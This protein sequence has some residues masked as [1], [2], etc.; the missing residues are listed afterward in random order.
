MAEGFELQSTRRESR[1]AFQLTKD[2]KAERDCE[3]TAF[4]AEKEGLLHD[5]K[6]AQVAKVKAE[7]KASDFITKLQKEVQVFKHLKYEQGYKYRAQGKA[8]RYPLKV[9][10][11]R[12]DQGASESLASDAPC[13]YCDNRGSSKP[14][15]W[16]SHRSSSSKS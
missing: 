5:L 1:E 6:Q 14:S 7:K 2:T 13:I 16:R 4:Q 11:S 15:C 9:G 3:K 12:E 8:L 10:I